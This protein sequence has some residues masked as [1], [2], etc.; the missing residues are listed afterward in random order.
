MTDAGG[1]GQGGAPAWLF[2]YV[3]V[4]FLMLIAMTILA[5][6]NA[7]AP[8][9]GEIVVP[10]LG[11]EMVKELG[12][13]RGAVWQLRVHPPVE[14]TPGNLSSPFEL[15]IVGAEPASGEVSE[16]AHAGSDSAAE[17]ERID[18]LVLRKRLLALEREV[19]ARPLLAPHEDSRSQD[20]LD[21][22]SLME[23]VWPGDRR[24]LIAKRTSP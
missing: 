21:A 9:L 11:G 18:R 6:Q 23:E 17:P 20:L 8:D 2:S 14:G 1:G 4:A 13:S 22:V 7:G 10:R 5:T 19:G 12:P 15:V 3:D 16:T 24:A